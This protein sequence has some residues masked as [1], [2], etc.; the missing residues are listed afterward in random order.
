MWSLGDGKKEETTSTK[1][2]IAQLNFS[3]EMAPPALATA[4]ISAQKLM[5]D[6]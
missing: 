6:V 5:F 2:I 3:L 4:A 1:F